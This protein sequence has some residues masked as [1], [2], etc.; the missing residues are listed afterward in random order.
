MEL[1]GQAA[2]ARWQIHHDLVTTV[3]LVMEER[4]F[5]APGD[6][7][8]EMALWLSRSADWLAAHPSAGE[9]ANEAADWLSAARNAINPDPPKRVQI[10]PCV[11]VDCPGTLTAVVRAQ[12]SLLPSAITCSWWELL[13]D[14]GRAQVVE[15]GGEVHVWTPSAWHSLGRRMRSAA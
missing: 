2:A 13:A 5:T 4:G 1:N 12:D 11:V 14:E 8:A 7:I 10:G 15:D 9:R 6:S 3:R